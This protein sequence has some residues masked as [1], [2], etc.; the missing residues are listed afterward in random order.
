[1]RSKPIVDPVVEAIRGHR[2]ATEEACGNDWRRLTNHYREVK[3]LSG[4]LVSRKPRR[5]RKSR[6]NGRTGLVGK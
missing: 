4:R 1:M 3:P 2:K 6:S 5:I